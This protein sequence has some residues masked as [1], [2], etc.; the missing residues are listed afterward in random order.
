[1][2]TARVDRHNPLTTIGKSRR[3]IHCHGRRADAA[4]SPGD[5]DH[6]RTR[7]GLASWR[8]RHLHKL[9]KFIGLVGHG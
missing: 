9:A 3:Q 6:R 2:T 5:Y 7:R 4:F 8:R 1:M